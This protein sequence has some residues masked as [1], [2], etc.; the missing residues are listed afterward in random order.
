M[1]KD[2]A[3]LSLG[4]FKDENLSNLEM[5]SDTVYKLAFDSYVSGNS[6]TLKKVLSSMAE[7]FERISNYLHVEEFDN[8]PSYYFGR[9]S[10]LTEFLLDIIK[11]D[12]EEYNIEGLRKSYPLLLPAL[13][14]IKK[15]N[16]VSGVILQKELNLKSSSN[17]SN[18]LK[19]ISKFELVSIHK[20]GN[21]NFISLTIKGE[22]FLSKN[23]ERT[24]SKNISCIEI[25]TLY[26]ILDQIA[27][28]S[29]KTNPSSIKVICTNNIDLGVRETR[30]L[31]HKVDRV[32]S[33]RD[34]C[35]KNVF[36]SLNTKTS[37][38]NSYSKSFCFDENLYN[39]DNV[40]YASITV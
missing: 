32:F 24:S 40:L 4:S 38:T 22:Y 20:V 19:R 5:V 9:I 35:I 30:I 8:A 34:E 14:I 2:L 26:K 29:R 36:K 1:E 28:E 27:E 17:L 7:N 37:R 6:E 23:T 31:K 18:F 25:G 16:T 39:R 11:E 33:N 3:I 21:T 15:H 12:E 13:E 10:S